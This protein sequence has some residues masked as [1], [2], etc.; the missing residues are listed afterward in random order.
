MPRRREVHIALLRGIN[1]GK[2][3]RIAMADLRA[4]VESLGYRDVR[5][6]LNSGNIVYSA[7]RGTAQ[8][9]AARIEKALLSKLDLQSRVT[10]LTASEL[11]EIIEDNPLRDAVASPSRFLLAITADSSLLDALSPLQQQ[12]WG[13]EALAVGKRAAYLWS[14]DGI[15]GGS[16]V[17]AV[18]RVLGDK[19]TT[20]NWATCNRIAAVAASTAT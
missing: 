4:L 10:G 12:D 8:Q 2:A 5:T 9:S 15:L 1:V 16:L 3:K 13:S 20:R 18:G 17:E 7:D 11:E 14:P 6:I 19:M